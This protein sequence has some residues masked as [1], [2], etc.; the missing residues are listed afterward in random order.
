MALLFFHNHRYD[1]AELDN[2]GVD[3]VIHYQFEELGLYLT[4]SDLSLSFVNAP[5][6]L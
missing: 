1:H 5:D 6:A 2:L 3:W 4:S